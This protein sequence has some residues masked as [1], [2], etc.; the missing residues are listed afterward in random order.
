M[1]ADLPTLKLRAQVRHRDAKSSAR[2]HRLDKSIFAFDRVDVLRILS[3][4][5]DSC[6]RC[7]DSH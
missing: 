6:R 3:D 2:T 7:A 4:S 5:S 1:Q